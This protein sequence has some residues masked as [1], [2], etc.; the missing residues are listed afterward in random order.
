MLT[1]AFQKFLIGTFLCLIIIYG[2]GRLYYQVTGGFTESNI[3][4]NLTSQPRWEIDPLTDGQKAELD[5]A[6]AQDFHYLGKGCQSYVF[7]SDDGKYVLK[8]FKYQRFR[9]QAW[10][11]YFAFIPSLDKYRLTKI[12]QKSKKL[13]NIF[14]SWKIAYDELQN[15]TGIL[16]IHLN[17]SCD[18]NKKLVIYDKMGLPHTLD[19]DE[20]EFM[21]Q[22]RAHML[23]ATIDIYMEQQKPEKAKGLI[24]QLVQ[25]VLSEYQRGV[26]DNDHAL[27]QNTGVLDGMPVHIDV[28]QFV[29]NEG[30]KEPACYKQ[31]L[32]NKTYKFRIW[33]KKHHPEIAVY[34][35]QQL[36]SIIGEQMSQLR[37][38]LKNMAC[39]E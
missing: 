14:T 19:L 1:K 4:S 2:A 12:E 26:G 39:D 3:T 17:K 8:F 28:G 10:L 25:M 15:E 9:P 30:F 32:F 27:M 11:D 31:E 35:D 6:F 18:L 5:E 21:L 37:P 38:Q 29:R 36:Y 24:D 33:L 22:K 20:Y 34:L 7:A 23:T 13:E 16:Y